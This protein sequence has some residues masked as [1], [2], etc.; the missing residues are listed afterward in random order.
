MI[1]SFLGLDLPAPIRSQ[2]V[3]QQFL[4]PVKDRVPPE[5]LHITLLFLGEV[6]EPVLEELHLALEGARLGPRLE[7]RLS[8]LGLFGKAAPHNLHAVVDP[9]PALMALHAKLAQTARRAGLT[10]E[11][12]KFQPHVTL[13]RL[14]KGSFLQH[15]LEAALVRDALWRSD[16]FQVAE[17][18]LFRSTLRKSGAVYDVLAQYPLG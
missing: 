8:G 4:L 12:R 3:L 9:A 17:L 7:L 13:S 6:P 15:E 2:I 18:T 16:P 14:P 10:L 11:A 1:R 5:N